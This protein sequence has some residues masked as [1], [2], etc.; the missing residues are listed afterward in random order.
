MLA[1]DLALA[2]VKKTRHPDTITWAYSEHDV[3]LDRPNSVTGAALAEQTQANDAPDADAETGTA[4][5]KDATKSPL[6]AAE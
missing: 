6:K 5:K 1:A 4:P 3:L 2:K